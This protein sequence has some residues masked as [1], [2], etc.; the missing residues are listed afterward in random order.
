MFKILS[1]FKLDTYLQSLTLA[2]QK[3]II[4]IQ[5]TNNLFNNVK[6]MKILIIDMQ[7]K[8]FIDYS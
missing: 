4:L 5:N 8:M 3:K 6:G 7:M 2:R 1:M